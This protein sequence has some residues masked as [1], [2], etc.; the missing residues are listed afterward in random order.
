MMHEMNS[1]FFCNRG[2]VPERPDPSAPCPVRGN[3]DTNACEVDPIPE[4]FDWC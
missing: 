2:D 3:A 1:I 4:W